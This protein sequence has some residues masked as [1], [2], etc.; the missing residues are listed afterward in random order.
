MPRLRLL[1]KDVINIH[2]RAAG[3]GGGVH[4]KRKLLLLLFPG[5]KKRSIINTGRAVK[6][7]RDGQEWR[8][9]AVFKRDGCGRGHPAM[10]QEQT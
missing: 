7:E 3:S 10:L 4:T 8:D 5:E 2:F 6:S 1:I 9:R